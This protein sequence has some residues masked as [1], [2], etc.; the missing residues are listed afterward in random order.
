MRNADGCDSSAG[1]RDFQIDDIVDLSPIA[2][3]CAVSKR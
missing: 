1:C 2:P 3:D